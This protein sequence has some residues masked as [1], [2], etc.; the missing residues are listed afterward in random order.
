MQWTSCVTG[1]EELI[2]WRVS[3]FPGSQPIR[4]AILAQG[5]VRGTARSQQVVFKMFVVTLPRIDGTIVCVNVKQLAEKFFGVRSECALFSSSKL[6][7]KRCCGRRALTMQI[8]KDERFE[9]PTQRQP[10]GRI[11]RTRLCR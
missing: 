6:L 10:R 5:F 2:A 1:I 11:G 3:S 7:E 8:C 9:G 4:K